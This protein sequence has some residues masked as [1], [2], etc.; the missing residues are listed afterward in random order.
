[1]EPDPWDALRRFVREWYRDEL[2]APSSAISARVQAAELG[3]G[4]ALPQALVE[5]FGLTGERIE[6]FQDEFATLE[7]LRTEGGCLQVLT[8]FHG[9]WFFGVRTDATE[10]DPP[11]FFQGE[12]EVFPTLSSFL[13]FAVQW[14]TTLYAA[15]ERF[16]LENEDE[17]DDALEDDDDEVMAGPL[18]PA[19]PSVRGRELAP[20]HVVF[21]LEGLRLLGEAPTGEGSIRLLSDE[22]GE[23]LVLSALS[24]LGSELEGVLIATRTPQAEARVEQQVQAYLRAQG[25][26]ETLAEERAAAEREAQ[27]A[28]LLAGLP[29]D[30]QGLLT[31]LE[32]LED[33]LL[34]FERPL[35]A[36]LRLAIST[37]RISPA[38]QEKAAATLKKAR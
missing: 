21:P 34:R 3:L 18:G 4:C 33:K 16:A 2:Q 36:E 31:R 1:M 38:L 8:E 13:T 23:A 20:E 27:R 5:W 35:L 14:Q 28:V 19:A 9:S 26:L 29:T 25:A 11:V 30:A 17:D 32:S 12:R 24:D 10:P 37:G 7:T 6:S 22:A 15:L